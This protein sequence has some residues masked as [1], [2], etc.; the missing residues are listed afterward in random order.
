MSYVE[1]PMDNA[2]ERMV[3]SLIEEEMARG[4]GKKP[5]MPELRP[6][7]LSAAM[8]QELERVD[9]GGEMAPL[10]IDRY[11][12]EPP[13]PA[14]ASDP[15]AWKKAYENVCSQLE[16]QANRVVNLELAESFGAAAWQRHVEDLEQL[17]ALVEGLAASKK[18]EAEQINLKRKADQEKLA[19][20]ILRYEKQATEKV[21]K[22]QQL[23]IENAKLR[24][25]I[26]DLEAKATAS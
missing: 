13:E 22:H 11:S 26:A 7:R 6:L 21:A 23:E 9:K 18:R 3:N 19:P 25:Q 4:R 14:L 15:R 1:P 16:H 5:E 2:T 20:E 12:C 24:K 10:E 17:K 8:Q